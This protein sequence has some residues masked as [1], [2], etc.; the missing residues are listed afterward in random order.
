MYCLLTIR[1]TLQWISRW[2]LL[3]LPPKTFQSSLSFF[4]L[5]LSFP[6]YCLFS[7]LHNHLSLLHRYETAY[8]SAIIG[9]LGHRVWLGMNGNIAA[10]GSVTFNWVTGEPVDYTFWDKYEPG[11]TNRQGS[12][13][14]RESWDEWVCEGGR[15]RDSHFKDKA[16][17]RIKKGR[18]CLSPPMPDHEWILN[19][20][21][22]SSQCKLRIHYYSLCIDNTM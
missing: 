21:P 1:K 19:H 20:Q 9:E 8:F 5:H 7:F 10:D 15:E 4:A 6:L 17:C 3:H 12:K 13:D 18:E 14:E 2:M 16:N 22:L 11:E